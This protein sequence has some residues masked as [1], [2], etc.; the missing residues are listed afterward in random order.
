MEETEFGKM[1]NLYSFWRSTD[2]FW[3]YMNPLW[4]E[5]QQRCAELTCDANFYLKTSQFIK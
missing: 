3:K 2:L 1:F 5:E 4:S